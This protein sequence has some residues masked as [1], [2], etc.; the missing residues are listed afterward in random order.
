M[1]ENKFVAFVTIKKMKISKLRNKMITNFNYKKLLV[2][3]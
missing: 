1:W 2:L 3:Q